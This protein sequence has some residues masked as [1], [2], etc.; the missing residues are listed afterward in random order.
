M[1]WWICNFVCA[2]KWC[3]Y[4]TNADRW[5]SHSLG[6]FPKFDHDVICTLD[7]ESCIIL[8]PHRPIWMRS[9]PKHLSQIGGMWR[10]KSAMLLMTPENPFQLTVHNLYCRASPEIICLC[11]NVS[12]LRIIFFWIQRKHN[13]LLI[14]KH[15]WFL[16]C[17]Q[18]C[19]YG[20]EREKKQRERGK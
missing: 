16:H 4:S 8:L 3:N 13:I 5:K 20:R 10:L 12:K 6:V 17:L 11:F 1:I 7:P 9:N 15:N 18:G 14:V 19:V 2:L